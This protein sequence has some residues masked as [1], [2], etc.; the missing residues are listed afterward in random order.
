M[1]FYPPHSLQNK[2]THLAGTRS[3][4]F[5]PCHRNPKQEGREKTSQ[6]IACR[7]RAVPHNNSEPLLPRE[8]RDD[9]TTRTSQ[10]RISWII[11]GS[12]CQE[13]RTPRISKHQAIQIAQKEP[14]ASYDHFGTPYKTV[15][16][17]AP[18]KRT[19]REETSRD[20][21]D[22]ARLIRQWKKISK[23]LNYALCKT[24]K[25]MVRCQQHQEEV[26]NIV[27]GE[28]DSPNNPYKG[29]ADKCKINMQTILEDDEWWKYM[30]D[31]MA[32]DEA[33]R[34]L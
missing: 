29:R 12:C 4:L 15:G 26:V 27:T 8:T 20:C 31:C 28:A 18:L 17:I 7:R 32:P 5:L 6:D 30:Y 24:T 22:W 3:H 13:R 1:Q 2:S 33:H 25:T 23:V 19:S 16:D 34:F 9:N 11:E 14:Q 10:V 21:S